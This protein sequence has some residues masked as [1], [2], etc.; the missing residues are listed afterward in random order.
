MTQILF[1]FPFSGK[2][3]QSNLNIHSLDLNS[4]TLTKKLIIINTFDT[5]KATNFY[6]LN[7]NLVNAIKVRAKKM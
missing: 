7:V 6:K 2:L 1:F 5:P 3:K 4:V